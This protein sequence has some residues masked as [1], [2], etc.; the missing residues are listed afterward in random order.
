[1]PV[2]TTARHAHAN[3]QPRG[4]QTASSPRVIPPEYRPRLKHLLKEERDLDVLISLPRD[5]GRY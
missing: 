1:M 2:L 4:K 5:E 3:G